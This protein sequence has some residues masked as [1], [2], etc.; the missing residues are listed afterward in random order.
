MT[1][2]SASGMPAAARRW[3]G[4]R[5]REIWPDGRW[6]ESPSARADAAISRA[7]QHGHGGVGIDDA[8]R[9][10]PATA[11]DG[12]EGVGIVAGKGAVAG[13]QVAP[14]PAAAAPA[15]GSRAKSLIAAA[16]QSASRPEASNSARSKFD[17]TWMSIEGLK[18]A[19][20][21]PAGIDAVVQRARHDVVGVGGDHQPRHIQPHAHGRL[22]GENVA[23]IAGGHHEGARACPAPRWR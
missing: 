3:R 17:A 18:V 23:E 22:A 11:L 16:V 8:G 4:S 21:A 10:R 12:G 1:F 2:C 19:C 9:F 20:A 6:T 14:A 5:H 7:A 13:A 15:C